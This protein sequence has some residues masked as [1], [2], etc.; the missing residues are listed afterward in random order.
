MWG[1]QWSLD[2]RCIIKNKPVKSAKSSPRS[3][4][5]HRGLLVNSIWLL[6]AALS[7]PRVKKAKE[8][9]IANIIMRLCPTNLM[10]SKH[11][12]S[13][14]QPPSGAGWGSLLQA[15]NTAQGSCGRAA[16]GPKDWGCPRRG[17]CIAF[18][19]YI[20]TYIKVTAVSQKLASKGA[21]LSL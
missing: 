4:Q 2:H 14:N 12:A 1:P 6:D 8:P 21:C 7:A 20:H 18:Y 16:Q 19:I 9:V 10:F 17:V 3:I 5:T 13:I 11:F 15:C